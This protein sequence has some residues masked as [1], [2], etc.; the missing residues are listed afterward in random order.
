MIHITS[1]LRHWN[2]IPG[3]FYNP[4]IKGKIKGKISLLDKHGPSNPFS[5]PGLRIPVSSWGAPAPGRSTV[6]SSRRRSPRALRQSGPKATGSRRTRS[7]LATGTSRISHFPIRR[8]YVTIVYSSRVC[9]ARPVKSSHAS[10]VCVIAALLACARKPPPSV[11]TSACDD[12]AL[13]SAAQELETGPFLGSRAR[14]LTLLSGACPTL[15]PSQLGGLKMAFAPELLT[16][17][18]DLIYDSKI[19]EAQRALCAS[20]E[21]WTRALTLESPRDR[22]TTLYDECDLAR[23]GLLDEGETF[24]LGDLQGFVL[25]TWLLEQGVDRSVARRLVRGLM[26]ATA[27]SKAAASRCELDRGD[28]GCVLVA[29]HAGVELPLST[30]LMPPPSGSILELPV[31][32]LSSEQLRFDGDAFVALQQGRFAAANLD[33]RVV[34]ALR[35]GLDS[36]SETSRTL[37]LAVDRHVEA[38]ALLRVMYGADERGFSR[39]ALLV[40]GAENARAIVLRAPQQ[41]SHRDADPRPIERAKISPS[42]VEIASSRVAL[43]DL[44]ELEAITDTIAEKSGGEIAVHVEDEVPVGRLVAVLDALRGADCHFEFDTPSPGCLLWRPIL[45]FEPPVPRRPGDWDRLQLSIGFVGPQPGMRGPVSPAQLRTRVEAA[46]PDIGRCLRDSPV[47]RQWMPEWVTYYFSAD[48]RDHVSARTIILH[49]PDPEL[50]ECLR[51]AI[52]M[53]DQG[54]GDATAYASVDVLIDLPEDE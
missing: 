11:R 48:S 31:V 6:P 7:T 50:G 49:V 15:D 36:P 17:A 23:L 30:S 8:V 22:A 5:L 43:A 12:R 32:E 9:Q 14:A 20:T 26:T 2:D 42:A 3:S 46:L 47:A 21:S 34:T 18:P 16:D 28:Y 29:R 37:V 10:A 41:W 25:H 45:G 39:Y 19:V 27:S 44:R 38:G 52:G 51:G 54:A 4:K 35:D 33:G 24:L 1:P 40:E 13:E 53:P